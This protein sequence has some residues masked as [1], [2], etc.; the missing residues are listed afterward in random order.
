MGDL[1][2]VAGGIA[3]E[4]ARVGD[5]LVR[6]QACDLC[7][8]RDFE[9][10]CEKDRRGNDLTTVV[11]LRCG[12]VSHLHIPSDEES[13]AY[14]SA[15][16]RLDYGGET[17][18]DARRLLRAWRTGRHTFR[19]LEPYLHYSDRIL[20]IGAGS[21]CTVKAFRTNG[22][23]A[24]GIDPCKTAQLIAAE[25]LGVPVERKTLTDIPRQPTYDVVMLI[26]VIEH[27]KSPRSALEH[28]HAALNTGGRFY[29]ECPNVAAPHAGPGKLLHFAHIYNFTPSTLATLAKACGFR[30]AARL[31]RERDRNIRLLLEKT[32]HRSL[33]IDPRGYSEAIAGV[34][35]YNLLTYHLRLNYWIG[36]VTFS[37]QHITERLWAKRRLRHLCDAPADQVPRVLSFPATSQDAEDRPRLRKAG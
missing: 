6:D 31:S 15:H 3:P 27:L 7:A 34:R 13:H 9:I 28:V 23:G 36:R 35:R 16:Y 8:G 12:L 20:E 4:V 32:N 10:I 26:H 25:E 17:P 24:V 30:V 33:E 29:V 18:L 37:I 2:R 19:R 11:C 21:G 5:Q 22:Y 14:Y 1:K